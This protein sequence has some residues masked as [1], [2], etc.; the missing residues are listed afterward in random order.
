MSCDKRIGPLAL[1]A[2]LSILLVAPAARAQSAE[3]EVLFRDGKQLIRKGKLEEGCAKIEASQRAE[4]SVGTL[5]NL[6]DCREK[7]GQFA[8]AWAAFRKAE[9]QAK[10]GAA[11][12]KRR[13]E[14]RRRISLLEPRLSHLVVQ[15]ESRVRGLVVRRG[16]EAVD[17]ALWNTAVPIDPGSYDVVAEA[18]GYKTW[19]AKISIEAK[20]KKRFIVTVPALER[21]AVAPPEESGKTRVAMRKS[22]R[23]EDL[24]APRGGSLSSAA[25]PR[26][27]DVGDVTPAGRAPIAVE[28]GLY[29]TGELWTTPR[30]VSVVVAG[31]GVLALVT[32]TY[33]GWRAGSLEGDADRRCPMTECGDAEALRINDRARDAALRANISYVAGGS[34]AAVA[35]ILW[36][37]GKPSIGVISP[38][39]SN[40]VGVELAG[41][42]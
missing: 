2:G 12:E 25:P 3:A 6:G 15:I 8:S 35:A 17:P 14:A 18:P 10:L 37:V 19:S 1:A 24:A 4:S 23:W 27:P 32:G 28:P 42:F 38:S 40:G 9:V 26:V 5:L 31:A 22:A 29:V 33:F 13:A 20:T 36:F 39:A 11:D 21:E 41:R 34:A 16:A 7:L 30:R